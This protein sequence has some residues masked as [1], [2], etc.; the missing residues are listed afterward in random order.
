MAFVPDNY[1]TAEQALDRIG[2]DAT[3]FHQQVGR[4]ITDLTNAHARLA[5]MAGDWG[6]AVQYIEAQATANPSSEEWQ[7]L[8]S[9]KDLL[10]ADFISMRNRAEAVKNAAI[11]AA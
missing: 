4:A 9:R 6:A 3:N 10:V 8:K 5:A 11:A 1:L 7:A 2:G